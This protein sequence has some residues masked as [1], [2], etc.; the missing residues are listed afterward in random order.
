MKPSFHGNL[1]LAFSFMGRARR[2]AL[3]NALSKY[4]FPVPMYDIAM[5]V[6]RHPGS[7]QD[8]IVEMT[9][10]DKATI[11]RDAQKLEDGGF[12]IRKNSE[13][14]RRQYEL[15]L[16]EAGKELARDA[17]SAAMAWQEKITEGFSPEERDLALQLIQRM[18]DNME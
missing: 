11:A 7:S 2:Q 15:Y 1:V 3:S 17:R 10:Y 14:D 18:A 9:L 8:S 6:D 4:N 12:L 16:T 5:Y 13:R